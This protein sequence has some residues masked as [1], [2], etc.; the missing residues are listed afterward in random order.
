MSIDIKNDQIISI[1]GATA[2]GKTAFALDLAKKILSTKHYQQVHL[3]SAD[4]KQVYRG[5]ENLTGADIPQDF[6][7]NNTLGDY[8]FFS[9]LSGQIYLH[10][11]SI[12]QTSE[13]WSVAHFKHLFNKLTDNLNEASCLLV[14]GGTGFYQQ[15]ILSA[16]ASINIP[17]DQALRKQLAKLTVVE[18]QAK[19]AKKNAAKLKS[20]NN[21]DRHNPRR[22]IRAIEIAAA[23]TNLI[24]GQE[25]FIPTY[26]LQIP[27]EVREAKIRQRVLQRF[28]LAKEEVE[29]QLKKNKLNSLVRATLGF[30]QLQQLIE[31]K[32]DLT[33]CIQ[34]WQTAEIQYAKRQDTWWKKREVTRNLIN[35]MLY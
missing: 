16:A 4:S 28:N 6:Q 21:S 5:L 22:L 19:L 10:G 26:Y 20:M 14:V 25:N 1:V 12:I 35:L 9:D 13:E 3:L 27:K 15:Q 34:L 17:P 8:Q 23:D 33:T 29:K 11:V 24:Q 18:L 2:T 31:G 7:R 32:I 30:V